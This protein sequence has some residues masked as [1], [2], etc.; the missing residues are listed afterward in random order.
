MVIGWGNNMWDRIANIFK[1]Q[2]PKSNPYIGCFDSWTYINHVLTS[3]DNRYV[4]W[5][6]PVGYEYF[7]ELAFTNNSLLHLLSEKQ[8]KQVWDA[9]QLRIANL[10]NSRNQ[11]GNEI[12]LSYKDYVSD[13]TSE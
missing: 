8:R 7:R 4:L 10:D 2:E 13:D 5:I 3:P 9:I 6:S 11:E 12:L 1:K